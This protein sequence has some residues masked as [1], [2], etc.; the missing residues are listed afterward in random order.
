MSQQSFNAGL[1]KIRA[2][3]D[4]QTSGKNTNDDYYIG[5]SSD[6]AKDIDTFKRFADQV[7]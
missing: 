1:N 4:H 3:S 6:Q 5:V 7:S 2:F